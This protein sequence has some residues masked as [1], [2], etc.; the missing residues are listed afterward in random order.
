MK[1]MKKTLT[2]FVLLVACAATGCTNLVIGR[3]LK[4]G[5]VGEIV[6]GE[7]TKDDIRSDAWF[8]TPLHSCTG[9]DGEI[10]VYRYMTGNN[11]VEELTIGFSDD[12]VCCFYKE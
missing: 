12:V 11:R 1:T 9:P 7:T 3:P 5:K 2:A 4:Q 10:W 6:P 8:G